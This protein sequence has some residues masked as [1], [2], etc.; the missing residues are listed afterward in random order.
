M[1]EVPKSNLQ[2]LFKGIARENGIENQKKLLEEAKQATLT[3]EDLRSIV[4]R[5]L[6]DDASEGSGASGKK[7]MAAIMRD[8][9]GRIDGGTLARILEE[10]I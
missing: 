3:E 4:K 5:H 10:M 7:V 6:H 8:N 1:E 9:P 2:M